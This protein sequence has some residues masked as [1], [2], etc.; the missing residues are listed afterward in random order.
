MK[1][2]TYMAIVIGLFVHSSQ[3]PAADNAPPEGFTALFNG[4]DLTNWKGLLKAPL[5]NPA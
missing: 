2:T 5:D 4:T 1:L 3:L